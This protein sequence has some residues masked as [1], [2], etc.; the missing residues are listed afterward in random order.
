MAQW[1]TKFRQ[2]L[3]DGETFA[4]QFR[5][6]IG[7]AAISNNLGDWEK[8]ARKILEIAT[9]AATSSFASIDGFVGTGA[10]NGANYAFVVGLTDRINCGQQSVSP[11][12]FA[13]TGMTLTCEVTPHAAEL[14]MQM[15]IGTLSRLQV[16]FMAGER[17]DGPTDFETIHLGQYQG[18]NWNGER[19]I[20]S[21]GDALQAAEQRST[22]RGEY[23]G[24]ATYNWF[25]GIGTT[26]Y[27]TVNAMT[28]FDSTSFGLELATPYD[29][30]KSDRL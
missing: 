7:T 27:T 14:A 22:D 12:K 23:K 26:E 9:H 25:E 29:A 19:Y 30:R 6:V 11:R 4:P 20:L 8:D 15:P 24:A 21:F 18:L 2:R 17:S 16:R 28:L 5:L 10:Y 1:S 13:Y 3:R